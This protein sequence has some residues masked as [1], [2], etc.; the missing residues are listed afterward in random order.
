MT[1]QPRRMTWEE[2]S[3]RISPDVYLNWESTI[4]LTAFYANEPHIEFLEDENR[5]IKHKV[6]CLQ[7]DK[8][9]L[10][11]RIKGLELDLECMKG[12]DQGGYNE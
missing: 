2:L 12:Q 5:G 10:E 8:I 6:E 3:K 1:N 7:M 9:N 4:V 11:S